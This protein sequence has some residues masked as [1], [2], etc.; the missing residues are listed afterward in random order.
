MSL[1][2]H[3][4]YFFDCLS[5][6]SSLPALCRFFRF[7]ITRRKEQGLQKR[8]GIFILSHNFVCLLIP[9]DEV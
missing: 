6:L 9:P 4:I 8:R 1:V 2:I 3:F 5:T 7:L